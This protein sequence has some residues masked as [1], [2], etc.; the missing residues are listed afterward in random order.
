LLIA[1]FQK[2]SRVFL[3]TKELVRCSIICSNCTLATARTAK[4][5]DIGACR[6][7]NSQR[8]PRI[9]QYQL[10]Y[11]SPATQNGNVR[12]AGWTLDYKDEVD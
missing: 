3:P 5:A 2:L 7:D 10:T 6:I 1:A 4:K 11:H 9:H 8:A 12:D